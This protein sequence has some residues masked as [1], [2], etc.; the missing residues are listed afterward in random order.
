MISS[1]PYNENCKES[2]GC[3]ISPGVL[4]FVDFVLEV[5]EKG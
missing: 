1:D 2:G 5:S 3:L 4:W